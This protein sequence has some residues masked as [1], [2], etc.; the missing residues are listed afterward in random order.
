MTT[1]MENERGAE[2]R[3]RRAPSARVDNLGL[4]CAPT[5]RFHTQKGCQTSPETVSCAAKRLR[6]VCASAEVEHCQCTMRLRAGST[7]IRLTYAPTHELQPVRLHAFCSDDRVI[8]LRSYMICRPRHFVFSPRQHNR[9][10]IWHARHITN[11]SVERV[12]RCTLCLEGPWRADSGSVVFR[13]ARVAC[14]Q[15]AHIEID[16]PSALQGQQLI[17]AC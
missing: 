16:H 12:A 8:G 10:V 3:R 17:G 2:V 11:H 6:G 13:S 5:A 1:G 7:P 14:V 4:S 9:C 15:Q